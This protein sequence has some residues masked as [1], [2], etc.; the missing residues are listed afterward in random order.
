MMRST[1]KLGCGLALASL[2]LLAG[3]GQAALTEASSA[4]TADTAVRNTRPQ[5]SGTILTVT[6]EVLKPTIDRKPGDF[7]VFKYTGS[8]HKTPMTL[9]ERVVARDGDVLAMDLTLTEGKKTETIRVRMDFTPGGR[10]EIFD[11]ARMEK[12]IEK[13]AGKDL[14]EAM[15]SKTLLAADANEETLGT[16]DVK[17]ELAGRARSAQK[18]SY[19]VVVGKSTATMSITHSDDFAWGDLFGEIKTADGN[20]L[21]RVEVVEAGSVE[22]TADAVMAKKD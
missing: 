22:P 3:C 15:M 8:F 6:K 19:R 1:T 11:V 13:P 17:V 9:T 12:G 20:V 5:D 16:E 18:T 4:K 21:Y 14:Y 10:G 2:T 7:V